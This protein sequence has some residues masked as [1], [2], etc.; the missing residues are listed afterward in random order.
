VA[1]HENVRVVPG[2]TTPAA[3]LL[4]PGDQQVIGDR[5]VADRS[6]WNPLEAVAWQDTELAVPCPLD[7]A[8]LTIDAQHILGVNVAPAPITDQAI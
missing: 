5:G 6:S 3:I 1:T 7:P 2:N 8:D 4:E